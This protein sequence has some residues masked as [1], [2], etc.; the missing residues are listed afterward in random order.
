MASAI[1]HFVVGAALA[2]VALGIV[3]LV[4]HVQKKRRARPK[5]E[6]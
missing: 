2:G 3:A 4:L 1:T 5:F 6:F